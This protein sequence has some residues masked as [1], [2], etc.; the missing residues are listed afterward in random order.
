MSLDELFCDVDDCCRA[1]LPAWHRQ[2]LTSGQRRRQRSC[3][4]V[5]SEI[6]TILIAFHQAGYRTFKWC[7]L[8]HLCQHARGECPNLC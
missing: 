6:L 1:C 5:L 4:V 8:S 7:Y 3:R 2:L